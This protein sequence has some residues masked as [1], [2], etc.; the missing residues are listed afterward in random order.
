MC[1]IRYES[2]VLKGPEHAT[3]L[4]KIIRRLLVTPENNLAKVVTLKVNAVYTSCFYTTQ[5]SL[6]ISMIY[7]L[8]FLKTQYCLYHELEVE[9]I[10]IE[11]MSLFFN[12]R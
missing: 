3:S 2:E 4:M 9:I 8:S 10:H 1:R 12:Q 11:V 6:S 7:P 5:H